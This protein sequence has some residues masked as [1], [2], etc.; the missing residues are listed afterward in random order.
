MITIAMRQGVGWE[1]MWSINPEV[2]SI[3]HNANEKWPGVKAYRLTGQEKYYEPTWVP[4]D[5][6]GEQLEEAIQSTNNIELI[7][8]N[9]QCETE[10]AEAELPSEIQAGQ[11]EARTSIQRKPLA[12]IDLKTKG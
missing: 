10:V 12:F 6:H 5:D 3:V 2:F 8:S 9:V 4:T 11:G 1:C 7:P